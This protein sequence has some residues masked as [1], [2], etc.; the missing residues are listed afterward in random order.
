MSDKYTVEHHI[1]LFDE[2]RTLCHVDEK[3]IDEWSPYGTDSIKV[4]FTDG[5]EIIWTW[6]GPGD[7]LMETLEH[8][9]QRI[10]AIRNK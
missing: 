3:Y 8:Y 2:Y 7:W 1:D 4:R 9:Y 10:A 6:K 5:K